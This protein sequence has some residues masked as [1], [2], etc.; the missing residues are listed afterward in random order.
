MSAIR[1]V[2]K[3]AHYGARYITQQADYFLEK[4]WTV[5]DR[6]SICLTN[7]CNSRCLMCDIWKLK[8][9]EY[10]E[11]TAEKWIDI[12][13]ELHKWIG[14]FFLSLSGGE[15]FIKEGIYDILIRF[16]G[17]DISLNVITNGIVF[18]SGRNLQKLLDTG[19]PSIS[20]SIDGADPEIHDRY[21]GIPGLHNKVTQV[22]RSIKQQK[23]EMAVTVVS[24]VMNDT[25]SQL[26]NYVHWAQE[27]GVDRVLFQHLPVRYRNEGNRSH[28]IM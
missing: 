14:P 2:N 1:I 4:G 24:I 21:R 27:L 12:I 11:I 3:A 22:I 6:V 28:M 5:P 7:R 17:T 20:F 25:I 23:P 8:E 19:L 26:V 13:E 9:Q 18:S 16:A 15:V 10:N